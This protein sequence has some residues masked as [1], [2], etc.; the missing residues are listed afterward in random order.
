LFVEVVDD[1]VEN[2]EANT[3]AIAKAVLAELAGNKAISSGTRAK[4]APA[5]EVLNSIDD[6][7]NKNIE[8]KFTGTGGL[9]GLAPLG[10]F[11][12]GLVNRKDKEYILNKQDIN[13][14]N[15]KVQQWASGASLTEQQTTQVNDLTPNVYDSDSVIR[16]KSNGL[17]NF[18]LNQAEG[19]LITDGVN[20]QFPSVNLF[21]IRD[22]YDRAS[23][24]QQKVIKET[25]FNK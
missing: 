20:V 13:A 10:Q 16:T 19:N 4:I 15:L 17:Y 25:Y 6:F 8:G 9:F 14:V 5:V 21:E 1:L 18:M 24:E 22:L 2:K 11:F 3:P 7:A 12:K 23:S